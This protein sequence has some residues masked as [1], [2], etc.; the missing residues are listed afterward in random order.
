M[1]RTGQSIRLT[2]LIAIGIGLALF[3]AATTLQIHALENDLEAI[4]QEKI[5]EFTTG[6][7]P[8]PPGAQTVASVSATK[9]YLFLGQTSGKIEV[10]IRQ[11]GQDSTITGYEYRLE[12]QDGKWI[13]TDSG[14]CAGGE[15]Q[16]RGQD[17]FNSKPN[18]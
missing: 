5:A 16:L 7:N 17:A 2:A 10:F 18:N 1:K 15:C 12:R 9:K 8:L 11:A 3:W 4:A 6:P 14:A 13:E